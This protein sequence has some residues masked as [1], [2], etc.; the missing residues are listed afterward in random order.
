[1]YVYV[2]PLYIPPTVDT[3]FPFV[4]CC[5]CVFILSLS[6]DRETFHS[7]PYQNTI[8]RNHGGT[9]RWHRRRFTPN[10]KRTAVRQRRQQHW[11]RH[12]RRLLVRRKKSH[13]D[14]CT[15]ALTMYRREQTAVIATAT[16][17]KAALSATMTALLQC[18]FCW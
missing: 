6:L 17:A 10:T 18:I 12:R 14:D 9:E 13:E 15:K 8:Y 11:L 3:S 5:V 1:M 16:T 7:N 2:W 4:L